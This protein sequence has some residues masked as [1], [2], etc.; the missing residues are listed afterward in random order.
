M[1]IRLRPTTGFF[2]KRYGRPAPYGPLSSDAVRH[3]NASLKVIK[4]GFRGPILEMEAVDSA[5][6]LTMNN[7]VRTSLIGVSD[8][9]A[10]KSCRWEYVYDND[11][12]VS[13]ETGWDQHGRMVWG[14]VYSPPGSAGDPKHIRRGTFVGPDNLPLPQRNSR[15]EVIEFEYDANG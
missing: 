11:Q 2:S 7:N 3:R 14:L 4:K 8:S 9:D 12:H 5:G 6:R 15:A 13:Y 10:F 1:S